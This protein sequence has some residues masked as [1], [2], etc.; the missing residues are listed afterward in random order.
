MVTI[1]CHINLLIDLIDLLLCFCYCYVQAHE[2]E[3]ARL[4][5]KNRKETEALPE[6]N[7]IQCRSFT[8]SCLDKLCKD[9]IEEIED[10]KKT[11][12]DEV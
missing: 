6:S 5:D 3:L 7:K 12:K 9:Y 10:K 4:K 2:G 8:K 11:H 1:F